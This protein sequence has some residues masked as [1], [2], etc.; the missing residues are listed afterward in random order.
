MYIKSFSA[1]PSRARMAAGR[2]LAQLNGLA[3]IW[4][5]T[6]RADQREGVLQGNKPN[7]LG[8]IWCSDHRPDCRENILQSDTTDRLENMWCSARG[9]E[10]REG[11]L[12]GEVDSCRVM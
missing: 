8:K 7:R 6:H 3:D 2:Q 11:V 4:C 1:G 10:K 5:S 12:Q 9:H